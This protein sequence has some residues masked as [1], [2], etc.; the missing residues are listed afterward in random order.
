MQVLCLS[1]DQVR[2]AP[3]CTGTNLVIALHLHIVCLSPVR[4][5]TAVRTVLVSFPQ[6]RDVEVN[7]EQMFLNTVEGLEAG[8]AKLQHV[9]FVSGE[10]CD[11]CSPMLHKACTLMM[12]VT[13][14]HEACV[15][16]A[17]SAGTK[18]YTACPGTIEYAPLV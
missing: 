7:Y 17:T 4:R 10:A 15:V 5:I 1:D 18:W 13:S 6:T 2:C 3:P 14:A 11:M 16:C 9:Q 12:P 8:G